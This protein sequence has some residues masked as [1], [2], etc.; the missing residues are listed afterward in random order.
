MNY[1]YFVVENLHFSKYMV[2]PTVQ[3]WKNSVLF[4]QVKYSILHFSLHYC[5]SNAQL[6]KEIE[7]VIW[8]KMTRLTALT[9]EILKILLILSIFRTLVLHI[10]SEYYT[11]ENKRQKNESF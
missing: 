2:G 6:H 10:T 9:L 11:E 7:L 4:Y 1:T 5:N 8:Q 3:N